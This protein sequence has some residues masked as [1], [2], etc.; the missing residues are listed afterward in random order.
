MSF[1]RLPYDNC[2]Y[3]QEL[4]ETTGPGFYQLTTP[5]NMCKPC[6]PQDPRVRLQSQGV[7]L[8]QNNKLID[9]DS[10]LIGIS[11]NLSKCATRKYLPECQDNNTCNAET[12][13]GNKNKNNNTKII[14][15]NVKETIPF[16]NCFTSSEDTRLSNPPSTLRGTGINRWEWL[17]KNPQ[18]DIEEPFDYQIS[19]R[20]LSKINHRPCVP[21]PVDQYNTHPEYNDDVVC[22]NLEPLKNT[23][24]VPTGPQ[25]VQWQSVNN[26]SNY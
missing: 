12:G 23:C 6:H 22:D 9:I 25:S 2:S 14:I 24:A 7:S 21:N 11:R 16:T 18:T 1:N 20:I 19:S 13:S 3:K 4:N 26:I 10:E 8:N 5:P 17:C 15:D